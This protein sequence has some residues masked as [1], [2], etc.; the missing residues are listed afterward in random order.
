MLCR[1]T[2]DAADSQ[3][4]YNNGYFLQSDAGNIY[5]YC[6]SKQDAVFPI[7]QLDMVHTEFMILSAGLRGKYLKRLCLFYDRYKRRK[8]K[9]KEA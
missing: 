5:L 8:L 7:G 1:L 2:V 9:L 3:S 6:I 4:S